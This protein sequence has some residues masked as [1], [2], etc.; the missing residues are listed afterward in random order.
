MV[1][2]AR[3]VAALTGGALSLPDLTLAPANRPLEGDFDGAFYSVIKLTGVDGAKASPNWLRQRLERA[4]VNSVNG[5]VDITN[6]GMHE[7]GQPL[8][9]FDQRRARTNHGPIR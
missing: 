5:V 6:L 2:I 9:A 8:H 1:G 3:E 4:G 7:Q